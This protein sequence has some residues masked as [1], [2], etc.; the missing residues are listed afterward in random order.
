MTYD[1]RR[2]RL[3]GLI[4]RIPDSNLYIVTSYGLRVQV[5]VPDRIVGEM[6][7]EEAGRLGEAL[8]RA[9]DETEP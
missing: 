1:L 8:V 6:T 3:K 5:S 4:V 2:L 7:R 9:L